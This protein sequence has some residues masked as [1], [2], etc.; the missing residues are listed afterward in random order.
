MNQFFEKIDIQWTKTK[1]LSRL[2]PKSLIRDVGATAD[3]CLGHLAC[4]PVGA[5]VRT[6]GDLFRS[7]RI[8]PLGEWW[9][10]SNSPCPPAILFPQIEWV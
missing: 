8:S 6:T 2:D 9:V 3:H 4:T 10:V 7:Q 5:I 1:S